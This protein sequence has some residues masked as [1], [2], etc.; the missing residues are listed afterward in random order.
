VIVPNGDLLSQQLINWTHDNQN[1]RVEVIVGVAYGSDLDKARKAVSD[2][3]Q[4]KEGIQSQPAPMVLVHQLNNSSV[5]LR[6][7]FWAADIN[8]WIDLKSRVITD[9]YAALGREGIQIPFPQTDLHIRSVDPDAAAA[10]RG[11]KPAS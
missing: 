7:L 4:G 11:D 2:A 10:L 6:V 8:S 3:L 1:R 9:I 5:D